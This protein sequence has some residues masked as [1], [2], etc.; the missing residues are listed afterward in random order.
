[1]QTMLALRNCNPQLFN[2]ITTFQ[3]FTDY[4]IKDSFAKSAPS[5]FAYSVGDE[6][7]YC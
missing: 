6:R 2:C 1:M 5:G 4:E 7:H 3:D